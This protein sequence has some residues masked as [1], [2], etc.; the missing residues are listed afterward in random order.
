MNTNKVAEIDGI[1]EQIAL[2][3]AEIAQ[4][5]IDLSLENNFSPE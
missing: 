1:N 5:R 2:I 3:D 4:L